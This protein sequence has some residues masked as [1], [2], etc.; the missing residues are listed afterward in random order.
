MPYFALFTHS[1]GNEPA[2]QFDYQ[3]FQAARSAWEQVKLHI[4]NLVHS[5]AAEYKEFTEA[6][7]PLSLHPA[8]NESSVFGRLSSF[9]A[10]VFTTARHDALSDF[11]CEHSQGSKEAVSP[12]VIQLDKVYDLSLQEL[13][14][15]A[16]DV[17]K[18]EGELAVAQAQLP[19]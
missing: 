19:K 14:T 7:S 11:V 15:L 12:A 2:N 5:S 18:L 17:A 9:L 4:I 1:F 16:A 13:R 6:M 8:P 3:F 10:Y